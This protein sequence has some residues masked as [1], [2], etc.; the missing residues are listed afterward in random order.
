MSLLLC[1]IFYTKTI[2]WGDKMM[3]EAKSK[4][5]SNSVVMK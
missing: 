3:G 2:E 1:I 4:F 5:A